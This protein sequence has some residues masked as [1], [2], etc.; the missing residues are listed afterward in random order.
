MLLVADDDDLLGLLSF[1]LDRAG[2]ATLHVPSV[3]QAMAELDRHP[4]AA[5]VLDLATATAGLGELSARAH[6]LQVPLLGLSVADEDLPAGLG[7]IDLL[8]KPVSPN[9]LLDRL[10]MRLTL[11]PPDLA[12]EASRPNTARGRVLVEGGSYVELSVACAT[13]PLLPAPGASRVRAQDL[14]P[15]VLRYALELARALA[16]E[17]ATPRGV[18]VQAL[19]QPTLEAAGSEPIVL[20][21][22]V[23]AR[24]ANL[25]QTQLVAIARRVAADWAA[26][27]VLPQGKLAVEVAA[28]LVPEPAPSPT[29]RPSLRP[30]RRRLRR[31]WLVGALLAATLLALG[32][33][34]GGLRGR[35]TASLASPVAA[36]PAKPTR[37]PPTPLPTPR[38]LG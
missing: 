13:D 14:L 15:S 38:L 23:H 36:P 9:E 11:P 32:E 1:M 16:A 26:T 17:G 24:V 4:P 29:L 2:F 35:S 6:R 8:P 5:V 31:L 20:D 21:L 33:L 34:F 10:R 22:A 12:A 28:A 18:D 37:P 25:D 3:G 30:R 19:I 7:E 27:T